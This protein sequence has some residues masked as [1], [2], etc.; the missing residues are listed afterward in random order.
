MRF[1]LRLQLCSDRNRLLPL[2]YQYELSAAIYRILSQSDV[3]YAT[4]LHENG[5]EVDNKKFKLF[6]FSNLQ[7]PRYEIDKQQGR[8][9]ILSDEVYWQMGFLP[10]KSTRK[11]IKGVFDRQT[12][13]IGDKVSRV[14]F[15]VRDIELFPEL[16]MTEMGTY[17]TL[18]PV[19]VSLRNEAG[20]HEYIGPEHPSYLKGIETGLQARYKAFYGKDY[21]GEKDCC[22]FRLID[23][24]KSSL[25]KIKADTPQQTY[26]RGYRY[27][28]MLSLPEP[29]MRIAYESGLGEKGSLGFGMIER[30]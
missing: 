19:V 12:F 7:I 16:E 1:A 13:S 28:L 22:E 25:I 9:K 20:R 2:N 3:E 26:V 18:S 11:F 14:D 27:R 8:L 6:T 23:T 30:L 17:K 29:L 15:V 10:D 5:F 4:W 24:P 21:E